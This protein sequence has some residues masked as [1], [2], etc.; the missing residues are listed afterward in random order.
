MLHELPIELLGMVF[1]WIKVKDLY[2]SCFLIS[3]QCL[4][5]VCDE[6][7][8]EERC[9]KELGLFRKDDESL[10][11]RQLYKGKIFTSFYSILFYFIFFYFIL[12]YFYLK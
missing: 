6:T 2:P 1:G 9:K 4:R 5:A 7:I 12:F 10:G 8:W 11:W 3:Q